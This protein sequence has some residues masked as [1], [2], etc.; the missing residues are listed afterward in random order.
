M[1]SYTYLVNYLFYSYCYT[2]INCILATQCIDLFFYESQLQKWRV[3]S[4]KYSP[5]GI[6]YT[7]CL[8]FK[9]YFDVKHQKSLPVTSIRTA[10]RNMGATIN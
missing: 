10:R 3:L 7:V 9:Y 5:I 1:K 8:I 4:E 6:Y 2:H